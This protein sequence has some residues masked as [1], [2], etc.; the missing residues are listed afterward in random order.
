MNSSVDATD[1]KSGRN[2]DGTFAA[3]NAGKPKGARHQA[4]RAI[5]KLLEGEAEGLARKAI[6]KALEGD[7]AALRLCL[8]R[9]APVR[10]DAPI[11][12]RLPEM[13][14]AEDATRAARAVLKAVSSGEIT[15]VEGA[16]VMSL[17]E[18]YRRALE[19]EELERRISA[20]EGVK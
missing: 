17:I 9:V 10:K 2:S 13:N 19:T 1:R 16:S 12:F 18:G 7:M 11:S 3:G 4:T 14:T 8:E 6:E 15:P 20:L 5:E